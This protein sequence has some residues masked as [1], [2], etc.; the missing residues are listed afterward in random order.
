MFSFQRSSSLSLRG[1]FINIT[2]YQD[3]VN[4]FFLECYFS[5]AL[6]QRRIQI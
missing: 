1:D 5:T 4:N 2:F 6:F 3:E